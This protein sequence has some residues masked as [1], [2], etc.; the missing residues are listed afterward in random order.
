MKDKQHKPTAPQSRLLVSGRK[1]LCALPIM[2]H[3]AFCSSGPLGAGA[4]CLGRGAGLVLDGS[5]RVGPPFSA[6]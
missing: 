4:F 2:R 6:G 1:A 5:N 3:G